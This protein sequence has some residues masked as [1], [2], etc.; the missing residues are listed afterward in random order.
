MAERN[1][2]AA[3]ATPLKET[4]VL[5]RH[6][7]HVAVETRLLAAVLCTNQAWWERHG[8]RGPGGGEDR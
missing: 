2:P 3:R 1:Q 7:H 5:M 4:H 6:G 8:H